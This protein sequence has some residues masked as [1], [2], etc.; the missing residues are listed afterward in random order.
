VE[1]G[2]KSWPHLGGITPPVSSEELIDNLVERKLKS[3]ISQRELYPEGLPPDASNIAGL[4]QVLLGQ[5]LTEKAHHAPLDY[6]LRK[7]ERPKLATRGSQ[8]AY[9][10]LVEEERPS[11]KKRICTGITLLATHSATSA[12][13][14]LRRMAEDKNPPD[15]ILLIIDSRQGL[16]LGSKGS[17]YLKVLVGLGQGRFKQHE[18][19][20][21]EYLMLDA[22][23]AVVGEGR[24]GDLEMELPDGNTQPVSEQEVIASHHRRDRYRRHPLLRELL[25]E[26]LPPEVPSVKPIDINIQELRQFI[27]AQ[28]AM[29]MGMSSQEVA[30]KY[31][32]AH[33]I[34]CE[35][36]ALFK[37]V[38]EVAKAMHSEALIRAQPWDDQLYLTYR[39]VQ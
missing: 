32:H 10:L 15:H 5:C 24:S 39:E 23:Q 9:H 37:V 8:P 35:L 28:L 36:E 18:L 11:D 1:I 21:Q 26:E 30:K 19:A 29:T 3:Q 16:R 31:H 12:A 27:M 20:F 7:L 14:T 33:K 13:S 6:T 4:L 2:V 17:D 25:T 38:D 34:H 22:L